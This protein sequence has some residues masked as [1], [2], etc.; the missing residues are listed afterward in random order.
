MK[1]IKED[2]KLMGVISP[3]APPTPSSPSSP[4]SPSFLLATI[5][6]FLNF[7]RLG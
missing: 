5:R 3:P 4:L 6:R 7:L 2:E 1:N